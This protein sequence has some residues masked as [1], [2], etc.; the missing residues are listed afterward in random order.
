MKSVLKEILIIVLLCCAI[1]LILGVVFYDY[2]PTNK[3]V[4]STVEAYKTSNT[5]KEEINQEVIDYPKQNITFEITDSDLK[6]YEQENNYNS[7]KA[8]PFAAISSNVTTGTNTSTSGGSTTT[9]NNTTNPDSTDH[10]FN[11]TGLK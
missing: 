11:S 3:V 4:P 10:F 9:K 6:L 8:N 7:G 5:I 1:C 2:I